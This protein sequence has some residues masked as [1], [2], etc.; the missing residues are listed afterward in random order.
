MS[1]YL[2]DQM[3]PVPLPF[4]RRP[5]PGTGQDPRLYGPP[6][7]PHIKALANA[8]LAMHR[9]IGPPVQQPPGATPPGP[10]PNFLP[11]PVHPPGQGFYATP[12]VGGSSINLQ[13]G[14]VTP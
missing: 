10:P 2:Y 3:P 14:V 5:V 8:I 1:D 9:L 13:T 11:P 7:H 12:G 4:A 6:I